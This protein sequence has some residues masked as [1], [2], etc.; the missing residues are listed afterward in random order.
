MVKE[1][2]TVR[3]GSHPVFYK[4]L[5]LEAKLLVAAAVVTRREKPSLEEVVSSLRKVVPR[6]CSGG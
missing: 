3:L 4:W 6:I 5:L 1:V 2:T